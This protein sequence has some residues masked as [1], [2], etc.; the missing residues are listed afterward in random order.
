M[1]EQVKCWSSK[2]FE[3]ILNCS[4]PTLEL[5]TS[6]AEVE[7]EELDTDIEAIDEEEIQKEIG[8]LKYGKTAGSDGVRA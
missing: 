6:D 2:H 5:E 7:V 8:S 1:R 4:E 3:S